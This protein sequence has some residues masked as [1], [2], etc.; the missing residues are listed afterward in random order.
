MQLKRYF[1]YSALLSTCLALSYIPFL[2]TLNS[3]DLPRSQTIYSQCQLDEMLARKVK[4]HGMGDK[5]ITAILGDG[6][7]ISDTFCTKNPDDSYVI[8]I[9]PP[10][11]NGRALEHELAH[12]RLGHV[13]KKTGLFDYLLFQEPAAMMEAYLHANNP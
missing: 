12:I 2:K 9:S 6:L 11:D 8:F 5:K 1:G 10:T 3:I 13:E 4:K 7:L